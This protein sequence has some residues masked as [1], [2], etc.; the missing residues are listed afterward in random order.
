MDLHLITQIAQ[1]GVSLRRRAGVRAQGRQGDR[2]RH[3]R[4]PRHDRPGHRRRLHL[5]QGH[6]VG[7][8]PARDARRDHLDPVARLRTDRGDRVLRVHLRPDRLLPRLGSGRREVTTMLALILPLAQTTTTSAEEESSNFL[9]SPNVGLMIWTLLAF[10]VTLWVLNKFAFPRIKE[11]LD[12]RA[13]ADRGLD[14]VRRAVRRPRPRR[15]SRSTASGSRRRARRRTTSSFAR[16]RTPSPTSATRRTR[17][18]RSARSCSSRRARTS[19]PRRAARSPR[20]AARSRT[21]RS[22]RPRR[23]PGAC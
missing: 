1:D 16:A 23:S 9:V 6:R 17:R 4:R 21:S 12:K 14:Q 20:S 7:D 13:A 15:C 19:T 8:P 3:R 18:A 11:A 22:R 10:L 2:A 5:R